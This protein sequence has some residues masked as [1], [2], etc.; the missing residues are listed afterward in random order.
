MH[1]VIGV[2]ASLKTKF[3]SAA[4]M[5][6]I[7]HATPRLTDAIPVE[8]HMWPDECRAEGLTWASAENLSGPRQIVQAVKIIYQEFSQLV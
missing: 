1:F 2:E 3:E 6:W 4:N 7:Y 8:K 5:S